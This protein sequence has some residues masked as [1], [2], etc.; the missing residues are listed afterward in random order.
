MKNHIYDYFSKWKLNSFGNNMF[1]FPDGKPAWKFPS[2][3]FFHLFWVLLAIISIILLVKFL[4]KPTI[5]QTKL[6]FLVAWIILLVFEILK[7]IFTAGHNFQ[8]YREKWFLHPTSLC[9]TLLLFYPIY[10]LIPGK[11]KKTSNVFLGYTST[12]SLWT[13]LFVMVYP[14]DV[15][16]PELF[17]SFHTMIYHGTLLV[18]GAW[19]LIRRI[20]NITWQNSW[21]HLLWIF[22]V[23]FV[24]ITLAVIGNEIIYQYNIK[25]KNN[26]YLGNFF[27]FSHRYKTP[28]GYSTPWLWKINPFSFIT[29]YII[30]TFFGVGLFYYLFIG[31]GYLIET[32]ENYLTILKNKKINQNENTLENIIEN[33]EQK[34]LNNKLIKSTRKMRF[35]KEKRFKNK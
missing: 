19:A 31:L 13:G 27:N 16:A 24:V 34:N 32:I 11:L 1:N 10:L 33:N 12:I 18:V 5:K 30:T 2:Y 23:L 4:K 22:L 9:A 26:M 35:S 8:S 15:F 3:G 14:A 21:K 17:I 6:V 28:F 7:Q 20:F 29:I 25:H